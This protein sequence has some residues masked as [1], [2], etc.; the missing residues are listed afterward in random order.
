MEREFSAGGVIVR[1]MH[2]RWWLAAIEPESSRPRTSQS[3]RVLALP[4]GMVD[5]RERPEEAALREI[6]EETG[7]RGTLVTKLRDI[8]YF[9]VRSWGDKQRVFKVVSFFLF[10]YRSGRVGQIPP[11]MRHEVRSAEWLPLEEAA[12]LLTY[13]GERQVVAA[14]QQYLAAH[15]DLASALPRN[16]DLPRDKDKG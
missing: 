9:Y 5:T 7:L 12:R 14:A 6:G 11:D 10:L 15:P 16:K 13:P 4:K 1:R 8:K 3:K 2:H